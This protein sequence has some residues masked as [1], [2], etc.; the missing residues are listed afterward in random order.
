[1]RWPRRVPG[2]VSRRA[3]VIGLIVVLAAEVLAGCGP[4][5]EAAAGTVH[6]AY[7]S[8]LASVFERGIGPA[9]Q[10]TCCTF[11]GTSGDSFALAKRIQSGRFTPDDFV[12]SSPQPDQLLMAPSQQALVTWYARFATTPIVLAYRPGSPLAAQLQGSSGTSAWYTTIQQPGVRLGRVNPESDLTGVNAIF[13]AE[14]AERYYHQPGLASRIL[15]RSVTLPSSQ[16]VIAG[17]RSGS[18]DAALLFLVDVKQ[19]GLPYVSLPDQ[20]NLGNLGETD[21]YSQVSYRLPSG[22]TLTGAPIEYTITIPSTRTNDQGAIAFV[23][24]LFTSK[25]QSI[26]SDAGLTPLT[27]AIEGDPTKVPYGLRGIV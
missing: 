10:A 23:R 27:P 17:L 6:V 1:M 3:G 15:D 25:A 19:A 20:V 26:L 24:F 14:L 8:T 4:S 5:V 18:L 7:D 13:A 11:A 9:F 22:Q 12:S 2:T 21:T 16:A